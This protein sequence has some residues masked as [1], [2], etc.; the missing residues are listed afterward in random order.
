MWMSGA[1]VLILKIRPLR[2]RLVGVR[3]SA[4]MLCGGVRV[5]IDDPRG[6]LLSSRLIQ[7]TGR[8]LCRRLQEDR[9]R[10]PFLQY[11]NPPTSRQ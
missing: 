5:E 10:R 2:L 4:H 3:G 7:P 11:L 9:R 6:S 1:G 8:R